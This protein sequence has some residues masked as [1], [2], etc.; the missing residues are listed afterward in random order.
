M[1]HSLSPTRRIADQ[2]HNAICRL[3]HSVAILAKKCYRMV[4]NWQVRFVM[5]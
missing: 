5:F 1:Q 4:V 3:L 2:S